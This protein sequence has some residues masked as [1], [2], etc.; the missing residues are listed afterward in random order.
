[1]EHFETLLNSTDEIKTGLKKSQPDIISISSKIYDYDQLDEYMKFIKKE[2]PDKLV[3]LGG[4]TSTYSYRELLTNYPQTLLMRFAGEHPTAE[5]MKI[6]LGEKNISHLTEIP[7]LAFN[8]K[9][10]PAVTEYKDIKIPG[11]FRP[12]ESNV[13]EIIKKGG[14]LS[15]R[16]SQGCWGNC[17][18]CTHPGKWSGIEVDDM[19]SVLK[20][21]KDKYH[22]KS[23]FLWDDQ[24]AP[25]NHEEAYKRLERFSDK[26]ADLDINWSVSLR[27]DCVNWMD[28]S[29]VEKI[30]KG[31]CNSLFVGVES[32]SNSQLKRFGK[33]VH[34][35]K[36]DT[37]VT[38]KAIAFFKDKGIK[39]GI[40]WIGFD[41]LMSLKEL[42]DNFKFI[43]DNN[44]LDMNINLNSSLRI[45]KGSRYIKMVGDKNLGLLGDLQPNLFFH[46]ST[47][48]D[49]RIGSIKDHLNVWTKESSA[50]EGKIH[51]AKFM[52]STDPNKK[53]MYKS[54]IDIARPLQELTL[55][56][57]RALVAAFPESAEDNFLESAH[58]ENAQNFDLAKE[59]LKDLDFLKERRNSLLHEVTAK[60]D[61]LIKITKDFSFQRNELIKSFGLKLLRR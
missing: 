51:E 17:S 47:Y 42:K 35:S 58:N 27:A 2:F 3:V 4:P 46:D 24:V 40:G 14:I 29:L 25:K 43:E 6:V 41:P 30:K 32:G 61:D 55:K 19:V 23:V 5:L 34:E 7:N 10:K 50:I 56:Y 26:M 57:M 38:S 48:L 13:E 11:N 8:F 59:K 53:Q 36:I 39:L 54:Y 1:M 52:V 28:D 12:S 9:K 20:E 22:L 60:R 31:G 37:N 16:F 49:P 45:Q 44:L 15:F 21:W 33:S 18:F